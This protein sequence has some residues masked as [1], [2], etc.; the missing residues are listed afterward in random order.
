MLQSILPTKFVDI[1]SVHTSASR[2]EFSQ[3]EVEKLARNFLLSGGSTK[4]LIV[5]PINAEEF[6]VIEGHLEFY[7]AVRAKEIDDN[8]EMIQAIILDS[9]NE[10]VVLEQV[11]LLK[12]GVNPSPPDNQI[13]ERI[14]NL[15]EHLSQKI[16]ELKTQLTNIEGVTKLL[17]RPTPVNLATATR[18]EIK[19]A[20]DY[21]IN[22]PFNPLV[23]VSFDTALDKIDGVSRKSWKENLKQVV[24]LKCGIT[25]K[26]LDIFKEVF[27]TTPQEPDPIKLNTASESELCTVPGIGPQKAL[28][29]LNRIKTKGK[30][31]NI[32]ELTEIKGI[33]LNTIINKKWN[34]CFDLS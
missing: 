33:S 22:R 24:A 32:N 6:D 23:G 21:L 29:I 2:S 31:Q 34:E 30:F 5:R 16:N 17:K 27:Y 15:E 4:P 8:F 14:K 7:A 12:E 10:K 11:D 25:D 18:E 20:L 3:D 9:K 19:L 13:L 1:V 26:K 28:D